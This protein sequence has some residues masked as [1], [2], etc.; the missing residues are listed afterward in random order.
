MRTEFIERVLMIICCSATFCYI[1]GTFL[2]VWEEKKYGD[3]KN[4]KR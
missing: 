2:Y 4:S 3:K 1:A